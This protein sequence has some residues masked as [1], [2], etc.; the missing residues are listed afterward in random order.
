MKR[1]EKRHYR[2]A[3]GTDLTT[4]TVAK[5]LKLAQKVG[6]LCNGIGNKLQTAVVE[7]IAKNPGRTGKQA[8]LREIMHD[9]K[10]GSAWRGWLKQD[11][12]AMKL[13][14]EKRPA[15]RVPPGTQLAHRRG[16][17]A[18]KGHGYQNADLQLIDLHKTQHK[19]DKMGVLNKDRGKK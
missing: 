11:A 16:F 10:V 13:G 5:K 2:R 7:K 12:N 18:A 15:L 1:L 19:Y 14:K 9:D 17:E 6:K 4:A 3:L 8:R